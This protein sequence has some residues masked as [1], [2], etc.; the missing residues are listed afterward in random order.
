MEALKQFGAFGAA[1]VVTLG[2]FA[3]GQNAIMAWLAAAVLVCVGAV[4]L[5]KRWGMLATALLGLGCCLYLF[6]LKITPDK[7][8]ICDVSA[9]VSCSIVNSSPASMLFGIPIALLGAGFFLGVVLAIVA[10]EPGPGNRLFQTVGALS[11]VGCLYSVYLGIT[12]LQMGATCPMCITIYAC[13]GLLLATSLFGLRNEQITLVD[14]PM[15]VVRST[16]LLIVSVTFLFVVLLGQTYYQSLD[17][18]SDAQKVI[19]DIAKAQPQPDP[20]H[21]HPA[22]P[23]PDHPHPHPQTA[24]NPGGGSLLERL[25][26]LYVKPRGPGVVQLR[27]DEPV[28]GDPNAPFT[29]VEYACFGCPHCA[30]A[31]VHLKQLV[32]EAPDVK[33]KFRSFPLTNEC[34][35]AVQRGGRPEVCR[36]AMAARCANR[37]GKFWEYAEILF[38]NQRTLG[39][40]LLAA[41]AERVGVDFEAFSTCMADPATLAAVV[42][43]GMTGAQVEIMGTP[44]MFLHGVR[45][46][47]WVEVCSGAT[48]VKA[49]ID[50]KKQ[51]IEL[52]AAGSRLCP[53]E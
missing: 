7:P 29:V 12:A 11:I 48:G 19:D 52:P 25:S 50:A 13:T 37:Q 49:L 39:E 17:L 4:V 51:G 5:S 21:P 22:E 8:S 35:S 44:T 14:Q 33:V 34:N 16:S 23:H 38:A 31:F 24:P 27:G 9:T 6:Q 43:D 2:G 28:L 36:A 1:A 42:E 10:L 15:E 26:E 20:D 47:E 3:L 18:R 53:L 30:Q 41:A 45:G 32:A 40:P 46:D